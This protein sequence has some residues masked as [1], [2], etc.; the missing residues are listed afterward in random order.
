[1]TIFKIFGA[2]IIASNKDVHAIL[3]TRCIPIDMPNKP[4]FYE[5]PS[6]DKATDI[7]ARLIAWRAHYM[8]QPLP[9]IDIVPEIMGRLWDISQTFAAD[10]QDGMSAAIR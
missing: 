5:N 10:M 7:K 4:G 8:D 1:M 9:E 3:G 6:P 2:T